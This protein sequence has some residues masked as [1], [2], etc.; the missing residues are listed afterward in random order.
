[1]AKDKIKTASVTTELVDHLAA[2][3][4][5][6]VVVVVD[7]KKYGISDTVKTGSGLILMVDEDD[8]FPKAKDIIDDIEQ[9]T[10][11]PILIEIN[12][13]ALP[14]KSIEGYKR[15][16]QINANT[17]TSLA[18][19]NKAKKLETVEMADAEGLVVG[20]KDGNP[21]TILVG[22]DLIG[23]AEI[24]INWG[25]DKYEIIMIDDLFD[26]LKKLTSISLSGSEKDQV[27]TFVQ[28]RYGFVI[29]KKMDASTPTTATSF[30]QDKLVSIIQD[31]VGMDADEDAIESVLWALMMIDEDSAVCQYL[32]KAR[33]EYEKGR[34]EFDM[35]NS[36]IIAG[37]CSK[38]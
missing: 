1:M 8:D 32:K 10:G 14:I 20:E 23:S 15:G 11:L 30:T 27:I 33:F 26:E 17:N 3:M 12:G 22:D 28:D 37:I 4:N 9:S 13:K 7:G 21:V 25:E 35:T 38:K 19:M 5:G 6:R 18:Y 29:G 2:D 31:W 16:I 36:S 24:E 34:E